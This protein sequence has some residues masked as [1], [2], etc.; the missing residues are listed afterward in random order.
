MENSLTKGTMYFLLAN[1][2][3]LISTY[4]IHFWLGRSLSQELYGIYGIVF[5][6]INITIISFSGMQQSISKHIAENL[7]KK[8]AIKAVSIK[9]QVIFS[10]ILTISYII[11]STFITL[12]F[13]EDA[14]LLKYLWVSALVM[15]L[16][17][18]SA[19]FGYYLNGTHKFKKQATQI[20]IFSFSKLFFTIL[21]AYYFKIMGVIIA[22]II[23]AIFVVIYGYTQTKTTSPVREEFDYKKLIRFALPITFFTLFF[24]L[25]M[26]L[27]LLFVKS[28]LK[29]NVQTAY[30]TVAA[31]IAKMPYSVLGALTLITLPS[32]SFSISNNLK[33][34][35]SR[36]IT[37]SLRFTFL[38]LAPSS[39]II[40][41]TSKELVTF[42]YPTIYT[43]AA[44]V[45]SILIFGVSFLILFF[46]ISSIFNAASKPYLPLILIATLLPFLVI[47]NF[48]L[49]NK[50]G[51]LGGAIS[52]TI[53]AFILL[54]WSSI[55]IY[56]KF[57]TFIPLLSFTRILIP[58]IF[59]FF[60][61]K[62]MNLKGIFLFLEYGFLFLIYIII[63]III[64]EVKKEDI[65]KL[66]VLIK[67]N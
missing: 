42:I 45:L 47:S 30:Y 17:G 11:I 23:A 56:K 28:I 41:S 10:L 24:T 5:T 61:A 3:M 62:L 65:N 46:I 40:S 25:F 31:L 22:F 34:R 64:R 53:F 59:L 18:I 26:N 48:I 51:I 4:T 55:L 66:K 29:D 33:E 39:F 32:L 60:L 7:E 44:P 12:Y 16:Y 15:P 57:K 49:I 54:I 38:I 37:Q 50:L 58:S 6:F 14:S 27:D 36:I 13:F 21:L 20:G 2:A 52:T 9:I 43:E 63:L 35:T 8:D 67:K 19:V 1:V